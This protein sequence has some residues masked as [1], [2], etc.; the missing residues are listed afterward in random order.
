MH[1]VLAQQA[2][3]YETAD[4]PIFLAEIA[5]TT[6]EM[7][8][9]DHLIATAKSPEEKLFFL[10]QALETLR[11]VF[12]RQTMFA[13]FELKTHQAVENGEALTGEALSKL[14][15]DLLKRYH[16]DVPGNAAAH[17]KIDDAYAMEWAYIPH[18]YSDF[19]VYQY[20]TSLAAAA[21]FSHGIETD[22]KMRDS[23]LAV[24]K[25]GGSDYPVDI[26]KKAGLDMTTPAPYRALVARTNAI[27][28]QM[29]ALTKGR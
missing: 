4:Y 21:Y 15:L 13:E 20:A 12:Y 28:D 25:A 27:V 11:G 8:L 17:V 9:Q 14:Y 3:P 18:F 10:N 19:Y 5:S 16:G 1:S 24:L 23:Y 22:S 6:N 7:L 29:E 2:Q 26:L